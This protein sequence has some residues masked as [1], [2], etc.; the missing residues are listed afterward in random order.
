M[1][2]SRNAPCRCGSGK[3][4]KKCCLR[5]DEKAAA[6]KHS[7]EEA[8]KER[9]LAEATE[10]VAFVKDICEFEELSNRAND[11]TRAERWAEAQACCRE[12]LDRFP[13]EID[14]HWRLYEC[15]KARGDLRQ[16]RI[17][18]QATL[19]MVESREGFDPGFPA[20]LKTDIARFDEL[21][22]QERLNT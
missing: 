21:I 4:Y 3:K 18:A 16:A 6:E 2:T 7:K 12:L 8:E 5:Q 9:L 22:G 15:C 13:E 20:E 11:L 19:N 17:H 14:G 10:E 1:G